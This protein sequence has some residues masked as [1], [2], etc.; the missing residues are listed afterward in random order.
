MNHSNAMARGKSNARSFI[1]LA[2]LAVGISVFVW[3]A[4][5]NSPKP[6]AQQGARRYA[7]QGRVVSID[8]ASQ[9]V[10]VDHETIPGFMMAMTMG[11]AVKDSLLL[12]SLSPK[13][14]I[15]ADVVVNGNDYWLENIVVVKKA[16]P[17]KTPSS[18]Q[19]RSV[20]PQSSKNK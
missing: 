13:D 4:G 10:V 3:L 17:T 12:D 2:F 5:C 20:P 11:Y 8:K 1:L 15:T 18:G 19:S 6:A 9:Q 7:L 14:Q 16:G